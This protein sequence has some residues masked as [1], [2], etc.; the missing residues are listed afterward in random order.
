MTT[1]KHVIGLINPAHTG[2]VVIDYLREMDA[3]M[4]WTTTPPTEP[5]WYWVRWNIPYI[6][7][8]EIV[9]VYRE[10]QGDRLF[11]A[12]IGEDAEFELAKFT[13]WLGPLPIPEPPI[14]ATP[15]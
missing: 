4:Q 3:R 12:D 11:V 10:H 8:V 13:H 14:D 15:K 9:R 6:H 5:G 1:L 7:D 2:S